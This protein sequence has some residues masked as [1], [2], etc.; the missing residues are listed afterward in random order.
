MYHIYLLKDFL[1]IK[2]KI[3]EQSCINY[4][5]GAQNYSR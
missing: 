5:L 1:K 3:K 4:V 2:R